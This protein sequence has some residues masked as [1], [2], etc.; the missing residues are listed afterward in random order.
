METSNNLKIAKAKC[1]DWFSLNI[2]VLP[3]D[4]RK[5]QL[6]DDTSLV[7]NMTRQKLD[8]MTATV[9]EE[10]VIP[11]VKLAAHKQLLDMFKHLETVWTAAALDDKLEKL[12]AGESP[13]LEH[14]KNLRRGQDGKDL[15][16]SFTDID[17]K[18]LELEVAFKQFSVKRSDITS[19]CKQEHIALWSKVCT[20]VG[21]MMSTRA[22]SRKLKEGEKGQ[23]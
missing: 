5:E 19:N 18:I 8:G 3:P 11:F 2:N 15:F 20:A 10:V 12:A 22:M 13:D 21:V 9:A 23:P 7:S 6:A 4:E 16:K 1:D 14:C 17:G